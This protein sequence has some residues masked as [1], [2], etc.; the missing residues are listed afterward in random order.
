LV[1]ILG[2]ELGGLVLWDVFSPVLL[3]LKL[4]GVAF[5]LS[6]RFTKSV[7]FQLF[8]KDCIPFFDYLKVDL[9]LWAWRLVQ[10]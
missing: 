10:V 5:A 3:V 9:G 4:P 7:P 8:Q 2:F 1:V 6:Y